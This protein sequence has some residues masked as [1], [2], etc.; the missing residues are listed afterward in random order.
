LKR[1]SPKAL[2]RTAEVPILRVDADS[3]PMFMDFAELWHYREMLY[4]L[5]VRDLKVRYRQTLLG[6]SWAV[7]QPL[8]TMVVFSV[9]FGNVAKVSSNGIPYP[10][11]SFVA[12]V[13]W[14]FF[15]NGV[16]MASDSLVGQAHLVRKVYF[17]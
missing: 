16:A 11:F 12:L 14:T 4:F 15:N 2:Q 5:I 8:I 6:V 13:P 3:Y 1:T 17:P 7:I 9:F 10:I